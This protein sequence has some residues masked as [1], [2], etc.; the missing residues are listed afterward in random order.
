MEKTAIFATKKASLVA[1]IAMPW[2][3]ISSG[4]FIKSY[5]NQLA[6]IIYTRTCCIPAFLRTNYFASQSFLSGWLGSC[7][8]VEFWVL[9]DL[10]G[11]TVI[12]L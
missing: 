10:P 8:G 12:E 1:L 6:M 9:Q 2:S 5:L 4:G 11:D 7:I 3:L